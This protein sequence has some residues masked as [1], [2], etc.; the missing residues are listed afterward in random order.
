MEQKTKRGR[1]PGVGWLSAHLSRKMLLALVA[2][3][4]LSWAVMFGCFLVGIRERLMTSKWRS[5]NAS[6]FIL[7]SLES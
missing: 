4:V 7:A 6:V 3:A 5:M 1:F 2:L